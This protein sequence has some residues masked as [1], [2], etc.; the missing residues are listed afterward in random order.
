MRLWKGGVWTGTGRLRSLQ[1]RGAQKNQKICGV[2]RNGRRG[3][4]ET[5]SLCGCRKPNPP[6]KCVQVRQYCDR[7]GQDATV[8]GCAPP[9]QTAGQ[10]RPWSC[11]YKVQMPASRFPTQLKSS[12][13]LTGLQRW[14]GFYFASTHQEGEPKGWKGPAGRWQE[15]ERG[16]CFR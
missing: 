4:R 7:R 16:K 8:G 13:E 9:S 14:L 1:D 5:T 12:G 15:T 11:A 2:S 10:P 3:N 6:G